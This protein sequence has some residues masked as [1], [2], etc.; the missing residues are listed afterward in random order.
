MQTLIKYD[1]NAIIFYTYIKH[2][3]MDSFIKI[4]IKCG[5]V[6]K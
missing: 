1:K 3:Y 2:K 4:M 5:E 6:W